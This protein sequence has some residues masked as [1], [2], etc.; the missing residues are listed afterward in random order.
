MT[1]NSGI[2]MSVVAIS[3]AVLV[4]AVLGYT[5]KWQWTGMSEYQGKNPEG[6]PVSFW[7]WLSVLIVPATLGL[8]G[9]WFALTQQQTELD[10]QREQSANALEVQAKQ[11]QDEAL[12][13]YLDQMSVLL[14]DY[15][16]RN[17]VLDSPERDLARSR[18]MAVVGRLDPIGKGSIVQFLHES[19]LIQDVDQDD[20]NQADAQANN[21]IVGL[22]AADL[23]RVELSFANLEN[24]DLYYSYLNGA[25]LYFANLHAADLR[26]VDLSCDAP[27]GKVCEDLSKTTEKGQS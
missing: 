10:N 23:K 19:D 3:L 5:Q 4:T 21:P 25:N 26:L 9:V 7:M 20:W 18:T 1:L 14:L 27:Q 22:V 24:T 6:R 16:L 11:A 12:Q 2:L 17:S 8:G 15:D 13:A